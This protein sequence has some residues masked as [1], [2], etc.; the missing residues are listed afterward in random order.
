[1]T[2]YY[3]DKVDNAT[4]VEEYK[5]IERILHCCGPS[6]ELRQKWIAVGGCKDKEH[7][8]ENEVS[9]ASDH[10]VSSAIYLLKNLIK[11]VS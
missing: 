7:V 9:I 1:M 5:Q 6:Q 10:F 2:E 4:A 8:W 3:K 11:E